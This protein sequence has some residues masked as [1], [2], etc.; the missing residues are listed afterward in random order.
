MQKSGAGG[1]GSAKRVWRRRRGLVF[2]VG[3]G[4][5]LEW[6]GTGVCFEGV[7]VNEW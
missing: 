2:G 5:F 3:L 7:G 1:Q 6:S 4:G